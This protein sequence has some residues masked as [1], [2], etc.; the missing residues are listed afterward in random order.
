LTFNHLA[1]S[2]KDLNR[3]AEFY[4]KVLSLNEITNRAKNTSMRWFSLGG[5]LE[6]HLIASKDTNTLIDTAIHFALA[7]S[8][9]DAFI[10]R[11]KEMNISFENSDGKPQTFNIRA[12]GV[13]Q[14]YFQD[15]DGYWIEVNN[16]GE[17]ERRK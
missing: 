11:M 7:T 16:I 4:N 15:P 17:M 14:I 8:D 1:L 5:N 6:L 2:V 13:K 10:H 3:S 12:D 9:F